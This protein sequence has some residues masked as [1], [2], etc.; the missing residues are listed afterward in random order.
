MIRERYQYGRKNE[1][2]NE[3]GGKGLEHVGVWA[4]HP[5]FT[6]KMNRRN[7]QKKRKF[8]WVLLLSFQGADELSASFENGTTPTNILLFLGSLYLGG[9]S[10]MN[11]LL[12]CSTE[13]VVKIIFKESDIVVCLS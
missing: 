2:R 7:I 10:P 4:V 8:F 3:N 11:P 1:G 6:Q 9:D 13:C 5:I 12:T